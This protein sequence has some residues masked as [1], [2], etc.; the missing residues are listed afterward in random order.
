[1][2]IWKNK[3]A[4]PKM[5][6][7]GC[8]HLSKSELIG[9]I[10]DIYEGVKESGKKTTTI[11]TVLTAAPGVLDAIRGSKEESMAGAALFFHR[12]SVQPLVA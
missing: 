11:P 6:F 12:P 10:H 2:I 4:K 3:D 7:I 5:S 1:V 8:P 9:W